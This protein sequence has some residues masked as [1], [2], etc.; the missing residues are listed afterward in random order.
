[1]LSLGG[2]FALQGLGSLFTS[3]G[4]FVWIG[5][6]PLYVISKLFANM[7]QIALSVFVILSSVNRVRLRPPKF[8]ILKI[9]LG[10]AAVFFGLLYFVGHMTFNP[11]FGLGLPMGYY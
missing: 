2:L 8:T 7:V 5:A 3:F 4:D 1:V 9:I 10:A 11:M 6:G